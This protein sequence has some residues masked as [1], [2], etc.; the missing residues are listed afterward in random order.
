MDKWGKDNFGH[1]GDRS[2]GLRMGVFHVLVAGATEHSWEMRVPT[3][4]QGAVTRRTAFVH[5]VHG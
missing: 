4:T 5:H 2:G 1:D 3:G